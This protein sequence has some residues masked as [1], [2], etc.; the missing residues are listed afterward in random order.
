M[1]EFFIF[2]VLRIAECTVLASKLRECKK[3][4]SVLGYPHSYV[5]GS[6]IAVFVKYRQKDG[7]LRVEASPIWDGVIRKQNL[8]EEN[9]VLFFISVENSEPNSFIHIS[10]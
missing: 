9:L 4:Q 2:E 7:V 1:F 6:T 8:G 10:Y 3:K 5:H